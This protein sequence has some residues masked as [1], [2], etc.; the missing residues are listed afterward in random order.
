MLRRVR[1]GKANAQE[2]VEPGRQRDQRQADAERQRE[3]PAPD[4]R[5]RR[6]AAGRSRRTSAAGPRSAAAAGSRPALFAAVQTVAMGYHSVIRS[7][8]Q[9]AACGAACLVRVLLPQI[10]GSCQA[11]IASAAAELQRI[12]EPPFVAHSHAETDP[13]HNGSSQ[14]P[15]EVR[16]LRKVYRR[17]G[18]RR[19]HQL[20]ARGAARSRPCWA[21]TARARPPPSPC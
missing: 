16:D 7:G 14:P 11:P 2:D 3:S 19:R 10:G 4:R 5:S 15:V 9:R 18:R 17:R 8:S 13:R 1:A 6:S 21:A 12:L 20:H